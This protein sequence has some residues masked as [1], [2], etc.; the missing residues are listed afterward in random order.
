V[1]DGTAPVATY[2]D[3][4]RARRS[5]S[6][7]RPGRTTF[8]LDYDRLVHKPVFRALQGKTQVVT[9]G[10]ADFFRTRLTHTIEVAQ[11]ARRLAR[12]LGTS[13][14]IVEAAAVL[15]D[16]GH[17]PFG[18]IGEEELSA[19][20]DEAA[21]ARGLL[22]RSDDGTI[23][24]DKV[25]GFE[26]NAQSLRLATRTI[27]RPGSEDGI[28]L[29]RAVLDGATKYP[30]LRDEGHADKFCFY[31]NHFGREAME[32]IRRGVPDE[33]A[34][35]QSFEAQVMDWSDDVTYAIHDLEDWYKAG[36]LPLALLRGSQE[37]RQRCATAIRELWRLPRVDPHAGREAEL[38]KKIDGRALRAHHV[39]EALDDLF[40]AAGS[41]GVL[42][43]VDGDFDGSR[44]AL[45][46]VHTM[47]QGLYD[48]F[49]KNVEAWVR[50]PDT[51]RCRHKND[52]VPD[53]DTVLRNEVIRA[54]LRV[55]VTSSSRLVSQQ[56]GQ[57]RII[58]ELWEE[59][60]SRVVKWLDDDRE[61]HLAI[62]PLDV[63]A[64]LRETLKEAAIDP[65]E[66]EAEVIR[67]VAD[68]ISGL[69][70]RAAAEFHARLRGHQQGAV[71]ALLT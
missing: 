51:D 49:V 24:S 29:T 66:R 8:E 35:I 37:E 47:R 58:R 16:L 14:E 25:G 44:E 54:L 28:D 23:V 40:G 64:R 13:P 36:F 33:R 42:G 38:R 63:Q 2:S 31:P 11:L 68:R 22:K 45:A 59:H 55:Y 9:P 17:P 26:G 3:D 62:F 71:N 18:H 56:L 12:R 69:S 10:Q 60:W 48:L 52:L 15:H 46:R 57:R 65:T 21:A 6:G 61:V 30:W 70:D 39:E 43:L 53:F 32:W 27:W 41:A 5:G 4:D 20:V 50:D 19:Q 7:D 1:T 67:I 34:V